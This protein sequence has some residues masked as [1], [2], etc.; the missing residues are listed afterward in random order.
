M[1]FATDKKLQKLSRKELLEMLLASEK[2]A[3]ELESDLAEAEKTLKER[4]TAISQSGTVAEATLHVNQVFDTARNAANQYLENVRAQSENVE[5]HCRALEEESRKK[6]DAI[7]ADTEAQCA[8]M[9]QN[10]RN[11]SA[12]YWNMANE[13]LMERIGSDERLRA[14]A[15]ELNLVRTL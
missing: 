6:A 14:A 1:R 9:L 10:A 15:I 3:R 2:R 8:S 13:K 4:R 5:E 12:A 7:L 11:R